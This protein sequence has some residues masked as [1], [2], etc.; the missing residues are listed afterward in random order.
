MSTEQSTIGWAAEHWQLVL[1][2]PVV[3]CLMGSAL[4]AWHAFPGAS[5]GVKF[6]NGVSCFIIG[7]YAGPAVNEWWGTQSKNVAALVIL[8]CAI[9]GLIV[10]NAML[11]YLRTTK[12]AELPFLN[13]FLGS[14]PP[15][16]PSA[17]PAPPKGE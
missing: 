12:F 1:Q 2:H 6:A 4:A 15:M 9:G 8:G 3:V 14:M 11:E 13:R 10:M 5:R 7:I 17:P 16:S